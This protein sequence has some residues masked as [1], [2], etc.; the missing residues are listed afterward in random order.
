LPG[1]ARII[2]DA[3]AQGRKAAKKN[4]KE[5]GN[6]LISFIPISLFLLFLVFFATWRLGVFAIKSNGLG[7]LES[8]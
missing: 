3:K 6:P 5:W 1:L 2:L 8:P 7:L 4:R